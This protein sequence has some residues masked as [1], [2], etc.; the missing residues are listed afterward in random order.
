MPLPTLTKNTGQTT[1]KLTKTID[2]KSK[3]GIIK[4]TIRVLRKT[5][6]TFHQLLNNQADII[7][8]ACFYF[9]KMAQLSKN[10][11][12]NRFIFSNNR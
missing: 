8:K 9:N 1:L 12:K 6:L 7:L 4:N 10:Q 11:F 2:S 5:Y 3:K